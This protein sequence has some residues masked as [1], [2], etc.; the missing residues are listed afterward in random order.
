MIDVDLKGKSFGGTQVLGPVK[1]SMSDAERLAIL[2]PSGAGK[3]TLLR[4]IAG[5]DEAYD[6]VIKRPDRLSFMFQE[7][8]LLPWR[9]VRANLSLTTKASDAEIGT[10]L[11]EVGLSEKTDLFPGQ[12]S[13]GQQR[14]VALARALLVSPKVLFLDEPFASLDNELA[15]EM[16]ELT[17]KLTV[18]RGVALLLVTH[19]QAEADLLAERI[20]RLGGS[21]AVLA[22]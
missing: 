9:S 19:N 20:L 14:R 10:I 3:S 4:I 8:T 18:D 5:L 16:C 7:P 2:G 21:P 17:R 15:Q 13:L 11:S 12:L 6:G 1:F 22:D